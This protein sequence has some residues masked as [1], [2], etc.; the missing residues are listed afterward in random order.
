M[1]LDIFINTLK[2]AIEII[3]FYLLLHKESCSLKVLIEK[4]IPTKTL[5]S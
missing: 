2:A 5:K 3:R 1:L 4:P